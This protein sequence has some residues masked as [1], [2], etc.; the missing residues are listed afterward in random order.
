[1]A[2]LLD[3]RFAQTYCIGK[4]AQAVGSVKHVQVGNVLD[5]L[6]ACLEQICLKLNAS[7]TKVLTRQAQPPST[8]TTP[9]RLELQFLEHTKSQKWFGC[10]LSM[11]NMG[12]RQ[13]YMN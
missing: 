4:L 6:V 8:L 10:L 13:Q 3:Q 1:M 7:N 2:H 9:A 5:A 12:N 11:V